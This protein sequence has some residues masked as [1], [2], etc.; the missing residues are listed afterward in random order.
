MRAV[1][2]SVFSR[3]FLWREQENKLVC[4]PGALPS[5]FQNLI[6]QKSYPAR[7][8]L[9]RVVCACSAPGSNGNRQQR[10]SRIE[11]NRKQNLVIPTALTRS[12]V[13]T[14]LHYDTDT[15]AASFTSELLLY[16][17]RKTHS[18]INSAFAKIPQR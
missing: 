10:L 16:A 4:K 6:H 12:F 1:H 3:D 8:H 5:A 17:I 2:I 13:L 15:V 14:I 11:S 9:S 7:R 18:L